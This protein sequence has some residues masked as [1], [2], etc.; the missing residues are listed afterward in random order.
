[1]PVCRRVHSERS[2]WLQYQRGVLYQELNQS[3]FCKMQEWVSV[4]KR[5][6]RLLRTEI[7]N[8]YHQILNSTSNNHHRGLQLLQFSHH[9][10]RHCSRIHIGLRKIDLR[11]CQS[12]QAA[13][14]QNKR[15]I[16]F[17]SNSGENPYF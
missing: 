10:Q 16:H 11:Q 3:S 9:D 15:N 13:H 12:H 7:G 5:T 17:M 14:I 8:F 4:N 6:K 2:T 1:M